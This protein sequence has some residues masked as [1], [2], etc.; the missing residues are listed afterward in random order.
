MSR[1]VFFLNS[2]PDLVAGALCV[3]DG[4]EGHHAAVV[5]R[6]RVGEQVVLTDGRGAAL[7]AEVT[8]VGRGEV[9]CSVR[10]ARA[11]EPSPLRV[12]VVQAIPKG[13]RGE[14]AV[15]LLTEVGVDEIV[16][17]QAERCVSRWKGEKV[18]RGRAKWEAV[19]REAAK[20]SRR[21]WWPVVSPV[22][23]EAVVAE[24]I[25]AADVAWVLHE[26]AIE[27]L[28]ALL[29]GGVQP[30]SGRAVLVVGP[31]GGVSETELEALAAAGA[32]AVRLGPSVLRTSTAGVV[33]ATLVLAGTEPWRRR[34]DHWPEGS[35]DERDR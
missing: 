28:A 4:A 13:D 7:D 34:L 3:L 31:E 22:A 1:P 9:V 2:A 26:A 35:T 20:Q 16:P 17:W 5:R 29:A 14:L 21:T 12:T 19:A 33:A 15:D 23:D 8:S 24:L 11:V 18:G 32:A 30:L 6:V 27:P 25:G 10:A